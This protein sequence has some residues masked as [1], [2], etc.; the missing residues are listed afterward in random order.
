MS[1]YAFSQ[2]IPVIVSTLG[3]YIMIVVSPGPAFALVAQSA[4]SGR[5]YKAAG[6]T[7]G[8]ASAAALYAALSMAGLLLVIQSTGWLLRAVQLAGGAYL[9]WLGIVLWRDG[10]AAESATGVPD[11]PLRGAGARDGFLRGMRQGVTVN[12][13]NPKAIVFFVSVYSVLIPPDA[14]LAA[15]VAII[16]GGFLMELLWYGVSAMFLSR[17][18]IRRWY[19]RLSG[20]INRLFSCGL[21]YFGAKTLAGR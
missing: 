13:A 15:R 18:W 11:S 4:L 20:T 8:L 16:A 3:V 14:S 10:G 17:G 9:I 1:P 19:L 21:F 2:E 5:S 7:L 6:A 12:L